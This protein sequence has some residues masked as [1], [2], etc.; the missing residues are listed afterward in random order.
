MHTPEEALAQVDR[1]SLNARVLTFIGEGLGAENGA[2]RDERLIFVRTSPDTPPIQQHVLSRQVARLHAAQE[3]THRAELVG[4][5]EALRRA[6]TA[7]SAWPDFVRAPL[8]RGA[9]PIGIERAGQQP[10]DRHPRAA[11][12]L[13]ESPA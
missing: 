7:S 5:A 3:R 11:I 4:A 6:I 12:A 9:Q 13:R 8:Q 10:V 2:R 1:V